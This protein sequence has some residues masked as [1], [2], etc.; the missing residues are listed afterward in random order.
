[1]EQHEVASPKQWLDARIELLVKEKELTR[2]R[3]AVSAQRRALPWVAIEKDYVFDAPDGR[4]TLS[5]L[6]DGRSQ[7]IVKHYM[8]GLRLRFG[9]RSVVEGWFAGRIRSSGG[10]L[11]RSG[12][13]SRSYLAKQCR[14]GRGNGRPSGAVRRN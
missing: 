7:L 2:L 12:P 13:R 3:D 14:S 6:F 1:M 8:M 10:S 11:R 9:D 4:V 5:D